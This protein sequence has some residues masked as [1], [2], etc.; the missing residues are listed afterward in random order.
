MSSQSKLLLVDDEPLILQS[1]RVLFDDYT[2]FTAESGAD[3]LEL[4]KHHTIDVIISDQRMPKMSGVDFLRVA[5]E[6]SPNAIRILMTGYADLQAVVDSVNVGEIFRYVNKPWNA[7]KL[8][9][10]VRFACMVAQQRRNLT[11]A[12]PSISTIPA[13]QTPKHEEVS[14][15]ELLFVDSNPKHLEQFKTFFEPKY[16]THITTSVAQAFELIPKYNIAVIVADSSLPEIDGADFLIAVKDKYPNIVTVLMT[17]S[18]DAKQAIRMINEGNVYRYLV[19]PFPRESL[20]LTIES[21]IIHF[22]VAQ[23]NPSAN[24]KAMEKS[25][26]RNDNASSRN[27]EELLRALRSGANTRI[28]L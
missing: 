22:K 14:E 13:L 7:E 28:T 6:I 27:V 10:T 23:E 21:A 18:Q 26:F 16:K 25:F 11:T 15:Y 5:K 4:L 24:I 9:E 19:K 20:R 2:V 3:G 8:K 12:K 17:G 1:L